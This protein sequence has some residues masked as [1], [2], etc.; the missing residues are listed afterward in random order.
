MRTIAARIVEQ[1][2][3]ERLGQLGLADA[4]RAEEQEAAERA[5]GILQPGARAAHRGRHRAHRVGLADHA[6][7]ERFLHLE[8]FLALA[9]HHPVDRDAGPAADDAGDILGGDFLAQHR[10]LG[11]ARG[12]GELLFELRDRA[13]GKLAR[14]G[15]IARALRLVERDPRGV[16]LFLELGLGADL[17]LLGLPAL[18]SA[19]PIAAR[20]WRA[21]LRASRAGPSTRRRSPSSAPRARS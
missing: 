4:G 14:L 15:E 2:F 16:E 18:R 17:V 19:R 10:A 12:V 13:V 11:R 3:G 9:L 21:R 20:N 7:A 6:L 8:Q 5:V 1:E